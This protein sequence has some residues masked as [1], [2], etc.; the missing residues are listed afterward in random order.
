MALWAGL[1]AATAFLA[2][3]I[4][5][6]LLGRRVGA[7]GAERTAT[8]LTVTFLGNIMAAFAGGGVMGQQLS[9]PRASAQPSVAR[10][11]EVNA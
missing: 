1:A 6:D 2:A 3:D 8:M 9:A 10:P 7:P 11:V 5:Q 4:V